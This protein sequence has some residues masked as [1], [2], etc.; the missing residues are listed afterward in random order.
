[1]SECDVKLAIVIAA[2]AIVSNLLLLALCIKAVL[3]C[4]GNE[5][6]EDG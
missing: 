4:Y 6:K 5:E 1:M 2:I 3:D